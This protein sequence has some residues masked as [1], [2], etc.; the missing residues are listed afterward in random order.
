MEEKCDRYFCRVETRSLSLNPSIC[1]T[2][3]DADCIHSSRVIR[4]VMH[5]ITL[6]NMH[7]N[8]YDI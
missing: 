5:G 3:T 4:V 8:Q 2:S 7:V 6:Y 1:V